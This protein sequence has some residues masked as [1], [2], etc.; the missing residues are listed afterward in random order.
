MLVLPVNYA[1]V[2][3]LAQAARSGGEGNLRYI[4]NANDKK[5]H[6]EYLAIAKGKDPRHVRI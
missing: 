4:W 2:G 3:N 6:F 5:R 1:D